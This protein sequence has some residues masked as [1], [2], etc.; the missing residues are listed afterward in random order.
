MGDAFVTKSDIAASAQA[1]NPDD[2]VLMDRWAKRKG[3]SLPPVGQFQGFQGLDHHAERKQ[4]TR[5]YN[6][7]RGDGAVGPNV[8]GEFKPP[9][10]DYSQRTQLLVLT[11][12]CGTAGLLLYA[13]FAKKP[14]ID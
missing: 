4:L 8:G 11:L 3:V 6:V 10:L 9:M 14:I 1:P 2:V 5:D 7:R 13:F 12:A